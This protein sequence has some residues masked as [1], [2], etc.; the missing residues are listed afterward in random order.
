MLIKMRIN[1]PNINDST[2][3]LILSSSLSLSL[4]LCVFVCVLFAVSL[5]L[6][7]I[8]ADTERS[9]T[10]WD[11]LYYNDSDG[12]PSIA[13][14]LQTKKVAVFGL[15]DQ[16][17]YAENYADA[18]GE[19]HDVFQNLGCNMGY[20][21]TSQDGYEHEASKS[22]LPDHDNKFCGLLCDMVNQEELTT[23]RYVY[24]CNGI[25]SNRT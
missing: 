8:G 15:G 1:R 11:E 13:S 21:Y 19:L 5:P 4:S 12:I 2:S 18:T 10:G 14:I 22:I 23:E 17:S 9:G 24:V 6:S 16:I 20:G 3:L 25:N 7:Y